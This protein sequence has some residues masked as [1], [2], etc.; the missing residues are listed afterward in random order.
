L[1]EDYSSD[2]DSAD[3]S[4]LTDMEKHFN[5]RRLVAEATTLAFGSPDLAI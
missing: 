3:E 1:D 2:D 4:E 5:G